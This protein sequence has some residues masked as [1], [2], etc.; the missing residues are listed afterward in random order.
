MAEKQALPDPIW[1]KDGQI[2]LHKMRFRKPHYSAGK[3]NK[4]WYA[5]LNISRGVRKKISTQTTNL[6]EAK[7]IAKEKF[8]EYKYL[9][10]HGY[11]IKQDHFTIIA[12]KSIQENKLQFERRDQIESWKMY[13][14]QIENFWIRVF[15]EK[16]V[17]EITASDIETQLKH[18]LQVKNLANNTARHYLL[19]LKWVFKQ[20]L[21]NKVITNI[22]LFPS[23]RKYQKPFKPRP[24]FSEEEWKR[25]TEV[26]RTF[27]KDLNKKSPLILSSQM[28]YRR[29]LRDWCKLISYS[30]LR[31]G[32]ASLLKWKDW[33]I[34]N[35]GK[36]NEYCILKVRAEEKGASKTGYREVIGL[37]WINEFLAKRKKESPFN[38]P[39]DYIFCHI[40]RHEGKPIMKFKR[41]FDQVLKKAGIGFD[42]K[43][44]KIKGYSPYMLRGTYA[45]FRLTMGEVDIYQLAT[46]LGNQVG[47]TEKYYSKAKPKD[48]AETLSKV[49]DD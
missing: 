32:E 27:D 40:T 10:S 42:D 33:E 11:S 41:T 7:E 36:K 15:G 6:K 48:F 49:I 3:I 18:L 13:K 44:N 8:A 24:S 26:L 38:K 22:P 30:G 34:V 5:Q 17:S 29:A 37:H 45:T 19:G 21:S 35:K 2:I 20:A 43:G 31:T 23:L 47:I 4:I 1:L 14:S 39:D 16:K 9:N 28:H 12:R 46:N 25:F